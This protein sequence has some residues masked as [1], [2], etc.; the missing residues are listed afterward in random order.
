M[1]TDLI[2]VIIP[3]YKAAAYILDRSLS[4]LNQT[5]PNL[6][7]IF[8]DDCSPDNT[9]QKLQELKA[10]H[11]DKNIIIYHNEQNLGAGPTRN[12]GFELS[13]GKYVYFA[14]ADDE[15]NTNLLQ[16]AYNQ[17]EQDG[18]DMVIF[19]YQHIIDGTCKNYPLHKEILAANEIEEQQKF[20]L[21][22]PFAPWSKVVR[23]SLLEQ[24]NIIFPDIRSGQDFCWTL[25]LMCC[26]KKISFINDYL[27]KYIDTANSLSSGK[28]ALCMVECFKFNK[29][30][31]QKFDKY[32]LLSEKL[33]L[34]LVDTY[35]K[36]WPRI[37]QEQ[38]HALAAEFFSLPESQSLAKELQGFSL[39]EHFP[40]Y[41][42]IP[43]FL[44][45]AR[46]LRKTRYKKYSLLKAVL[47][48]KSFSK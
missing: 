11:L 5:Y 13:S 48:T 17:F 7:F 4:I 39:L 36:Y 6:E 14:D 22:V 38:K 34:H 24:H 47:N 18:S 43:K 20:A 46:E 27:Y 8:V 26:A 9:W 40:I 37:N 42:I 15:P 3:V 44:Q 23:K 45:Q 10:A 32:E 31:L 25:Q 28:H 35:L 1:H 29:S 19:A 33:F 16:M 12:K 2:S 41:K 30:T 21:D